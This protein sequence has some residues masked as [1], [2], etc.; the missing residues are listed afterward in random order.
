VTEWQIANRGSQETAGESFEAELDVALGHGVEFGDA[1]EI[2]RRREGR[3][4]LKW[5]PDEECTQ[6]AAPGPRLGRAWM[7]VPA[8]P[9]QSSSPG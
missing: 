3:E 8:S 5:W 7:P 1:F 2:A 9:A 4:I 6:V